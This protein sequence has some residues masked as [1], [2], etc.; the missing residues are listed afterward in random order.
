[1]SGPLEKGQNRYTS[2]AKTAC[3]HHPGGC[4]QAVFVDCFTVLIKK[5]QTVDM[6]TVFSLPITEATVH[7]IGGS[8]PGGL[9]RRLEAAF[10]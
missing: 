8:G 9:R 10:L 4:P 3:G 2:A 1:M 6:W 5:R 7:R